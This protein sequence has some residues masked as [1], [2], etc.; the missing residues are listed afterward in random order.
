MLSL[1][2]SWPPKSDSDSNL[3][4]TFSSSHASYSAIPIPLGP[5]NLSYLN[6]AVRTEGQI[7]FTTVARHIIS[8]LNINN[9][10][11]MGVKRKNSD[12]HDWLMPAMFERKNSHNW[13]G[14]GGGSKYV[15]VESATE[16]SFDDVVAD[17]EVINIADIEMM[18]SVRSVVKNKMDNGASTPLQRIKDEDDLSFYE[19]N[20]SLQENSEI[21]ANSNFDCQFCDQTQR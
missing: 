8:S 13:L 2:W 3:V 11:E 21:I 1:A 7:T 16:Y 4:I 12:S 17:I 18:D 20:D 14:S 9:H 5:V 6:D 10:S 15:K 19:T